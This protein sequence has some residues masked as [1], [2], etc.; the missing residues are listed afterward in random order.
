MDLFDCI[1]LKCVVVVQLA[2]NRKLAMITTFA[3]LSVYLVAYN[4]VWINASII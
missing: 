3:F 2:P 1:C 4:T